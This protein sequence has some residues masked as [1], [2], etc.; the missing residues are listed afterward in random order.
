M[1]PGPPSPNEIVSPDFAVP[2]SN[3]FSAGVSHQISDVSAIDVDY[4]RVQFRDQYIRFRSNGT[5]NGERILPGFGTGRLWSNEGFADYNGLSL[6]YRHRL[7]KKFQFQGSYTLSK[8]EGNNLAGSDEFRL[9]QTRNLGCKDCVLDFK[10]SPKD[11]PRQKGPLD[12]DA[13]HIVIL[14]GIYDL[15]ADFQVTGFLR[16]NSKR[17][18]NIFSKADPGTGFTYSLPPGVDHV[19][20]GTA[21][22]F[23]QVDMRISKKFRIKDTVNVQGILEVFNVFNAKNPN[24]TY[25]VGNIS[26]ATFG[27]QTFF[28]GDP[29]S[30]DQRLA[31]LGFRFEF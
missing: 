29:E 3:Q 28:A 4:V 2:Y 1:V 31:Q 10:N 20:S 23:S 11:D 8:I 22:S 5:V 13:R 18:F 12:T 17:P 6:S 16:A 15:P 14:S 19:N 7:S 26:S 30:G 9:G 24:S 25:T 27:T 21:T